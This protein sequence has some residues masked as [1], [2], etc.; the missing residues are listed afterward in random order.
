MSLDAR[1]LMPVAQ[2]AMC[3]AAKVIN[4]AIEN[5]GIDDKFTITI[6][7]KRKKG[8]WPTGDIDIST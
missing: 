6:K 5:C 8:E 7:I 1:S 3:E 2:Q 4:D